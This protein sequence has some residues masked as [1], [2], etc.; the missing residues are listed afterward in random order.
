MSAVKVILLRV[1]LESERDGKNKK[2]AKI[3][4]I[5]RV[6]IVLNPL[7]DKNEGLYRRGEET[8]RV[9]PAF[10]EVGSKSDEKVR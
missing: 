9:T 7:C 10:L 1:T 3:D 5:R 6:D 8:T 2:V 4:E